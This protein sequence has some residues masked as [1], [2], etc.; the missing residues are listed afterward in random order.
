MQGAGR[1]G[2]I[3]GGMEQKRIGLD[4]ECMAQGEN[5]GKAGDS[6]AAFKRADKLRTYAGTLGKLG[7]R[8]VRLTAREGGGC[9]AVRC[10][11]SPA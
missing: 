5:C 4:A 2:I 6:E 10:G 7:L 9:A 8:E 3:C 11:L 1:I